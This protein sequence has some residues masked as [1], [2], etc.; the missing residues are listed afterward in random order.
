MKMHLS[1]PAGSK[2]RATVSLQFQNGHFASDTF[3][4]FFFI[5][6]ELCIFVLIKRNERG[7]DTF[8]VKAG[9]LPLN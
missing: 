6:G 9:A 3:E 2:Q 1:S 4:C 8:K 5:A 7:G